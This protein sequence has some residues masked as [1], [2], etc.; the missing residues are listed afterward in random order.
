MKKKHKKQ[1]KKTNK[2]VKIIKFSFIKDYLNERNKSSEDKLKEALSEVSSITNETVSKHRE[3][4]LSDARKYIYPLSHSK[5][6]LVRISIA[7]LVLAVVL[8]ISYC[9]VDIYA[10]Q[11]SSGFIYSV[12]DVIPFPVARV[13]NKYISYHSY[14]FELRRNMHYY[15]SQQ[16]INFSTPAE[17]AQLTNLKQD[18]INKVTNDAYVK[19]LADKNNVKVTNAEINNEISILQKQNKLGSSSSVLNSVLEDYWGWN[20][21]DFRTELRT[22]ILQQNVVSKLDTSTSNL[23]YSLYN[24]LLKGADFASLAS[25]YSQDKSTSSNGG[26]YPTPI[27]QNNSNISP[28]IINE[29][30]QLKVGQISQP[31]NTGYSL[32]ILKVDSIS[33]SGITASHIQLNLQPIS[34]FIKTIQKKYPKSVFIKI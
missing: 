5:H 13:G 3:A 20:I 24:Q 34:N 6:R 32:D 33:S 27:N 9:L 14:L 1:N 4:V 23:A 17:K 12:S 21:S 15:E 11:S 30:N 8:F 2:L 28:I 7:L 16:G 31:I 25:Q 29:L 18:A 26:Q 10:F 19:I 22:E